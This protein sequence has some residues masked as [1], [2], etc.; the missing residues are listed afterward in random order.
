[1][2]LIAG[3]VFT[4][5][6]LGSSAFAQVS[7]AATSS[8]LVAATRGLQYA[9]RYS[10][11]AMLNSSYATINTST[12][13]GS[14]DYT[15]RS[16]KMPFTMNYAGGYNWTLTGPDYMGGQFHRLALGQDFNFRRWKLSAGDSVSYLPQSPL[17]G[18]SGIPGI[19]EIIGLPNPN[20]SQTQTILTLKTHI[21]DNEASVNL[22]HTLN[23]ATTVSF[24]GT[25]SELDFPDD[26]G[27]NTR[28]W[29]ANGTLTRRLNARTSMFGGYR[30]S[31]FE[32]PG[33]AVAMHTTDAMGGF[34][35]RIT[36]KLSVTASGG[37]EWINST[38]T[39]AIPAQNTYVLNGSVSYVQRFDTFGAGYSHGTNGGAGY[40]LGGIYDSAYGN[41]LRVI[42]RNLSLGFTGGYYR[43]SALNQN[44]STKSAFG[45]TQVTW[46]LS[47]NLIV[48]GNYTGT[49]QS[50]TSTLSSNVFSG[51]FHIISFG[52][53][54][55][56][57]ERRAT[58]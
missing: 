17:T 15:S 31:Q 24:G 2:K 57:R 12:V 29:G 18:F 58:P 19:G 25:S 22:E 14:V 26:N 3:V 28:V 50:T 34:Q 20:P 23:Y 5:C 10:E 40:L 54:L 33:T 43:T 9:F 48:F 46:Q 41:Y 42:N 1:M 30:Y 7:P 13:S 4:L 45:A 56:P 35:R 51:T 27:I 44:G 53:G 38:V 47:R 11:S 21:V 8:P 49:G 55:S 39:S 16:Q 6:C 36:R 52:F 37:P 32:F